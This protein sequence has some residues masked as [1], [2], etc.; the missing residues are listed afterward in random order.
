[1]KNLL[2]IIGLIFLVACSKTIDKQAPSL[3]Q[4]DEKQSCDFG[5]TSFNLTKHPPVIDEQQTKNP[6]NTGGGTGGGSTGGGGTTPSPAGVILLDF[7]G[8]LVSGTSWNSMVGGADINCASANLTASDISIIVQRVTND[9]SPFNITVTTDETVY[10][11]ASI[12]KRQRVVVTESWE[13]YGQAGG[14]SFVG[15]FTTGTNTPCFVFSSLLN[16]NLKNIAEAC[17][18]EAGHTLGL[19]HQSTYDANC[20]KLSEYNIGQGSGEIGWA[21]IMGNSYYQNLSLWHRGTNSVSCTTIQDDVATIAGVVGYRTDDYS[22]TIS[23]AASLTSSLSGTIN[24]S[25]DVDFFL[26]NASTTKSVSVVPFNVGV[27]NA[28]ADEDLILRVYNSQGALIS[29]IDNSS[30]LDVATTLSAGV[31]YLSVST[32]ANPF[33]TTY[34]MLGK[35]NITLN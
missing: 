22:N 1:M 32:T 26:V 34:G 25:S 28:G 20:I 35:Y 18:H 9:Y 2:I 7:N 30:T 15:S 23:G 6:H 10:N 16:Y 33:T 11:A 8:Q 5:L 24:N 14:T 4:E 3:N 13:W 31:Y 21:P 29:T 17:A 27:Y 12:Y 19:R